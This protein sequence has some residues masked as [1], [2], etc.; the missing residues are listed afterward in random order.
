MRLSEG[1]DYANGDRWNY[2]RRGGKEARPRERVR[3][4]IWIS[5]VAAV[6]V[7]E[8]DFLNGTERI[9]ESFFALCILMADNLR[10]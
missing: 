9:A 10:H 7:G 3:Y 6:P 8:M 5:R 2:L 1:G 4:V